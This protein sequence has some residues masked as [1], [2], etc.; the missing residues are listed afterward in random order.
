MFEAHAWRWAGLSAPPPAWR[1]DA[2]PLFEQFERGILTRLRLNTDSLARFLALQQLL[3]TE[4]V[5]ELTF[6]VGAVGQF[7]T[8]A[9]RKLSFPRPVRVS[10]SRQFRRGGAQAAFLASLLSSP[11]MASAT[12]LTLNGVNSDRTAAPVVD[13]L[14]KSPFLSAVRSLSLT[15]NRFTCAEACGL[16]RL[17]GLRNV[18]HLDVT[19]NLI[20]EIG[21]S[22]LA[23]RFG[24]GLVV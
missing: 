13:W 8:I 24:E 16:A 6:E 3:V 2:K 1:V 21:Q 14:A 10:V 12:A 11:V 17:A 23:K 9:V 22:V 18:T 15:G 19:H 20:G 7:E 5:G 4:P